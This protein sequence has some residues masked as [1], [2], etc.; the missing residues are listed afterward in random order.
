MKRIRT[1]IAGIV[2]LAGLAAGI[3]CAEGPSVKDILTHADRARGNLA[4]IIWDITITTNE[5]GKDETRGL[6]VTVK[7][8]NTLAR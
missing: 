3:A 2:V 4:G 6:T 7:G 5:E 8:N 1:I